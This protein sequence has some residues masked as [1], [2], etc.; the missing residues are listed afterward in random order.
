MFCVRL[1]VNYD[2]S[3]L[4]LSSFTH[5]DLNKVLRD[6]KLRNKL[7][8][9]GGAETPPLMIEILR[10]SVNNGQLTRYLDTSTNDGFIY[11]S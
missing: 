7:L 5:R 3:M 9:A 6:I 2:M 10:A 1:I 4:W 11:F 8:S